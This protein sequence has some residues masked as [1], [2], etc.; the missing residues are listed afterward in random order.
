MRGGAFRG[1]RDCIALRRNFLNGG[2]DSPT[3]N[4]KG[5]VTALPVFSMVRALPYQSIPAN[6]GQGL[7]GSVR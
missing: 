7:T 5:G 1:I 4:K 2:Q 6:V 3:S